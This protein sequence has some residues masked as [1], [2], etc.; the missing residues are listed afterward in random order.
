MATVI[1]RADF[2]RAQDTSV[3]EALAEKSERV[4][5]NRLLGLPP[6][7]FYP[8]FR[9]D[10]EQVRGA[11]EALKRGNRYAAEKIIYPHQ[12]KRAVADGINLLIDAA[13]DETT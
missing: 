13:V 12:S 1:R 6:R 5:L 7:Q 11:V 9:I 3:S 4:E 10:I 2:K 8:A